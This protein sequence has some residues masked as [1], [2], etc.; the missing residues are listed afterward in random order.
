MKRLL[1][2]SFV[3]ALV[4]VL[5]NFPFTRAPRPDTHSV[6]PQIAPQIAQPTPAAAPAPSAE[7]Y[8]ANTQEIPAEKTPPPA[9]GATLSVPGLPPLKLGSL[10]D[11]PWEK[12]IDALMR[13]ADLSETM[14][15]RALIQMLPGLPPEVLGH[16]AEEAAT[17]LPDADYAALLR[18]TLVNPQTHGMA[19]SV[20]FADLMQRPEAITLPILAAIAREPRHPYAQNARDN[21]Q[22]LLRQDFGGD[23]VK[24]DEAIRARLASPKR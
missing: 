13:R 21:L 24:W 11:A 2:A 23:W 19:M 1:A 22:L 15:A 18:P 5:L 9:T 20:L 6:A 10:D 14:K 12:T 16:A 8:P 17:R 7:I 4:A 3:I